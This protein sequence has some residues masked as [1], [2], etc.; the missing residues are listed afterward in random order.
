MEKDGAFTEKLNSLFEYDLV[1][2]GRKDRQQFA[3]SRQNIKGGSS[4]SISMQPTSDAELQRMVLM[5]QVTTTL[6]NDL[7]EQARHLEWLEREA[8]RQQAKQARYKLRSALLPV[9]FPCWGE[10]VPGEE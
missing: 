2:M 4:I 1:C 7:V 6:V 5:P 8:K 10:G 3:A 9:V